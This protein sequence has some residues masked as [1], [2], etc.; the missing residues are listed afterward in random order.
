MKQVIKIDNGRTICMEIPIGYCAVYDE[1]SNTVQIVE[2][3]LP[4]TWEEYCK[5]NPIID[6]EYYINERSEVDE[7]RK[8]E[9]NP[10]TDRSTI[11]TEEMVIAFRALMQLIQLRDCYRQGWTPD[12]TNDEELKYSVITRLDEVSTDVRYTTNSILSFQ[13]EGIC[14]EFFVNF[15]DLI[16]QAK[17]LI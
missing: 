14:N 3:T 16:E 8:R 13:T 15:K 10:L 2:S 4:K 1:K 6:W 7:I 17:P 9:R 11:Q 12:W 5:E